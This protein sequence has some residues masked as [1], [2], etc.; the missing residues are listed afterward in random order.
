MYAF[1]DLKKSFNKLFV[2]IYFNLN[3][4]IYININIFHRFE[5]KVILFHDKIKI[6]TKILECFIIKNLLL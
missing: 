2:L 4:I 5:F 1:I 6:K 3:R